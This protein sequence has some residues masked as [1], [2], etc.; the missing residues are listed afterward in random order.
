MSKVSQDDKN[1]FCLYVENV[2]NQHE[3]LYIDALV[4]A[5]EEF[6]VD[7]SNINKYLNSRIL[8]AVEYE[9][10]ENKLLKK[11]TNKNEDILKLI[12]KE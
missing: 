8:S 5:C 1:T 10:R 11:S 12:D 9:A 7:Y 6:G 3:V 4:I 2:V